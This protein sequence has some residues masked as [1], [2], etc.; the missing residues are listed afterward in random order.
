MFGAVAARLHRG[1]III[2]NNFPSPPLHKNQVPAR[3]LAASRSG[4]PRAR[5]TRGRVH[6]DE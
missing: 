4:V 3:R 2:N 5:K 6:Q 1:I